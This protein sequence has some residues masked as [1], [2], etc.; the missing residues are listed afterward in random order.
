LQADR[1]APYQA[2]CLQRLRH[3]GT[4][5]ERGRYGIVRQ[6]P[7]RRRHQQIAQIGVIALR[8]CGRSA[9][10]RM[11]DGHGIADDRGRSVRD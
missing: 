7:D 1:C 10:G 6:R 9:D 2:A 5:V 3:R 4:R 8:R 11:I